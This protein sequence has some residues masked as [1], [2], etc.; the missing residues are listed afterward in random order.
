M[1]CETNVRGNG[2]LKYKHLILECVNTQ[3]DPRTLTMY[4]FRKVCLSQLD[5]KNGFP[6]FNFVKA[7]VGQRSA[8]YSKNWIL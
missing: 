5:C 8:L 7:H 3:T 2:E 6:E 4:H 1:Y